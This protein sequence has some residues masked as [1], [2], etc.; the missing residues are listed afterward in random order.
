MAM[1]QVHKDSLRKNRV[2]LVKHLRVDEEFLTVFLDNSIL[3]SD[4]KEDIENCGTRQQKATKFLDTIQRRG[5]NA[6]PRF[7]LALR[8]TDQQDLALMVDPTN[9]VLQEPLALDPGTITSNEAV[10]KGIM[11]LVEVA[12][13]IT[14]TR[15]TQEDTRHRLKAYVLERS[16]HGTALVI[17]FGDVA[18]SSA[19]MM[20][21][22]KLLCTLFRDLNF[23]CRDIHSPNEASLIASLKKEARSLIVDATDAFILFLLCVVNLPS[24]ERIT[25]IF[26]GNNCP[27]LSTKPKLFF[28]QNASE[29]AMS[30]GNPISQPM[31]EIDGRL[32]T[33][34]NAGFGPPVHEKAHQLIVKFSES[35]IFGD[36]HG[37]WFVRALAHSIALHAHFSPINML[38]NLVEIVVREL[39]KKANNNQ[40]DQVVLLQKENYLIQNFY[41]R[42]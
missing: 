21:D 14:I 24:T 29:V 32:P 11:N 2:E 23:N 39:K 13:D 22:S 15:L 7:I 25:E 12:H 26:D 16:C 19:A 37:S 4:M 5:N 38:L 17:R 40:C 28:F 3:T 36:A 30:S 9:P 35:K 20:A 6:F 27:A 33:S 18:N 34:S 41:F 10:V 8:E 42:P 1:L 31:D